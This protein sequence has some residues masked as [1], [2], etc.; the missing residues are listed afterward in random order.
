MVAQLPCHV[1][2][3]ASRMGSGARSTGSTLSAVAEEYRPVVNTLPEVAQLLLGQ[4]RHCQGLLDVLQPDQGQGAPQ[5]VSLCGAPGAGM[6]P[7]H[8]LLICCPHTMLNYPGSYHALISYLCTM[9]CYAAFTSR[10]GVLPLTPCYDMLSSH[11]ALVCC[12][13]VCPLLYLKLIDTKVM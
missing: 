2:R 4:E 3:S 5:V 8:H 10:F 13:L 7:S 11:H 1:C 6:L 9:L 12:Q